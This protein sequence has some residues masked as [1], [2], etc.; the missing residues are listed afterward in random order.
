MSDPRGGL[1]ERREVVYTGRV[2]G[3]GFRYGTQQIAQRFSVSGYVQN[4]P[5][6][7]VHLVAEG[8]AQELDGFL[9][10]LAEHWGDHIRHAAVDRRP[11]T[12][13][14]HNFQIRH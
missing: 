1:A 11:A 5:D 8:S 13:T 14:F 2:Q 3:V 9:A 4:R 12:G 10:A 7:S 6:G